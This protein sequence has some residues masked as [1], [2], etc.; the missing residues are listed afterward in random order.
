[1]HTQHID[2]QVLGRAIIPVIYLSSSKKSSI[3]GMFVGV[4][5]VHGSIN[6]PTRRF[7]AS[8][9]SNLIASGVLSSMSIV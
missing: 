9:L 3:V 7:A 1:M 8:V 4:L 6:I 5:S 2:H